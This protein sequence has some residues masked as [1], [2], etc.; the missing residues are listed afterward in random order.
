MRKF[1]LVYKAKAIIAFP[2]GYG[3]L[4]EIFEILTLVQTQKVDRKDIVI[5]L[6]GEKYWKEI[7]DFNAL[8]KYKTILPEDLK[9]FS[10]CSDPDEAFTFLKKKLIKFI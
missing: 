3:T 10:F 2:G 7:I 8:L 1:W 6:Y 9:I 4:D 5:L